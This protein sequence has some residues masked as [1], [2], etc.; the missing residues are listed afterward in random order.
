MSPPV[1]VRVLSITDASFGVK[2][3]DVTNVVILSV[4]SSSPRLSSWLCSPC[5]CA[6][7]AGLSLNFSSIP[8]LNDSIYLSRTCPRPEPSG[9]N[10]SKKLGP[11]TV[12]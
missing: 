8:T 5:A 11:F 6:F 9:L 7:S 1:S 4:T 2:T 3:S 10:F 12:S